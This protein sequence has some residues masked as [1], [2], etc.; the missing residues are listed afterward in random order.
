LRTD[1]TVAAAICRCLGLVVYPYAP[2]TFD[3]H[4]PDRVHLRVR[5]GYDAEAA[6]DARQQMIDFL[7]K[8]AIGPASR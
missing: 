3:M 7:G 2:H 6:A 4:L 8:R 5:L 1:E